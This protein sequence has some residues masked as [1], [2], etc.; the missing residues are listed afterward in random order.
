M[1]PY[2]RPSVE[3][4]VASQVS[5]TGARAAGRHGLGLLSHRRHQPGRLQR[6]GLQLGASPRTWPPSTARPSTATPGGWSARC[7]SPR[8]ARQAMRGRALRAGEVDLLLPRDRQPADRPRRGADPVEAMID[9]RPRGD[10][11]ARRRD[12][13]HRAAGRRERRLRLLPADGPQLGALGGHEALLRADRPL[14]GPA[15]PGAE[16]Q[17]RGLDGLGGRQQGR[18]HR[19][20]QAAV[21]A[22]IAQHIVEKGTANIR[23]EFARD[24]PG[25]A[26]PEKAVGAR[27]PPF[28]GE[29]TAKRWRGRW[30]RARPIDPPCPGAAPS[31]TS[32]SPSPASQGRSWADWTAR[33]PPNRPCSPYAGGVSSPH[34]PPGLPRPRIGFSGVARPDL[35]TLRAIHRGHALGISYENLDVQ[36]GRPLST[37]PAEAFDKIVRRRRGGWC[38]EMNGLMGAALRRDRLQGHPPGRRRP[39]DG[40]RR[41]GRS[42]TTWSCWWSSTRGPGSPTWASATARAIPSR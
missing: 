13:P 32:W 17:P 28:M 37:S 12:R 8:P 24:A 15:L 39:P 19:P 23:P 38:Y 26:A 21:G 22:R 29:G 11:H 34:G 6:A 4:A 35:A 14:R 5:P 16:R 1:T 7:T 18:V 42:A 2:S 20:G 31:T 27:P 25:G 41:R 9:A 10:R 36:L 40:P 33:P 3:I 30:G